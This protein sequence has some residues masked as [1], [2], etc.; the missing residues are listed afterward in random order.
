MQSTIEEKCY[1]ILAYLPYDNVYNAAL[2][3]GLPHKPRDIVKPGDCWQ[4][5]ADSID[6]GRISRLKLGAW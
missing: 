4:K 2:D 6:K 1:K 5:E 3:D